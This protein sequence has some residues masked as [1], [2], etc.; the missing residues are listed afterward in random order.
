MKLL[1]LGESWMGSSA[2]SLKE[3]LCRIAVPGVDEIDEMNEDLYIPKQRARWLRA[4]HRVL[5]PAYRR[6]LATAVIKKCRDTHP[7]VL[8]VY[9]GNGVGAEL[10]RAVKAMGVFTVNVLPDYSPHVYGERLR[11]AMGEYDLVISTKPFHPALWQSVYGYHN[12]CVFVPHGYDSS[13]HLI[14]TL[15]KEFQYDLGMVATW[16]PEYH[17]LM[18]EVANLLKHDRVRVAIAGY[19]WVEKADEFPDD[20]VF[21]GEILGAGYARWA[22]RSKILIAPV[23]RDVLING[24]QQPG[25]EDT[26]RTYE[27]AA[28]NCFFIHRRTDYVKTVYEEDTEVP[29]FDDAEELVKLVRNFLAAD[30]LRCKMAA[31]AHARAV[32]AYSIDSRAEQVATL[33]RTHTSLKK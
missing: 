15:P 12:R 17:A 18:R 5:A 1:F 19:G 33:I 16:R 27:L 30:E 21:A 29:L 22:Q 23:N 7:D 13:A 25:D 6:E 28:A 9:K 26:T 2:R 24:Q 31:A 8:L 11:V 20:W 10:V 3:S 32:P 14:T 4:I